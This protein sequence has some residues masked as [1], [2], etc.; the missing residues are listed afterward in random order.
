MSLNYQ[1]TFKTYYY[2]A[3]PDLFWHPDPNISPP[4]PTLG[5]VR[6]KIVV[7]DNFSQTTKYGLNYADRAQFNIQDD[8]RFT[9]NW[10]LYRK[11]EETKTQLKSADVA[12]CIGKE[13]F[14][15]NYLSGA[16]GAFPY[17][18]ASGHITSGTGA[19]RLSTGLTTLTSRGK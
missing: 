14:F 9:T 5:S 15:V 4:K 12:K 2:D 19:P 13:G 6:G 3:N 17:F 1:E 16:Y 18:V 11:W 8:F 10:D 7:L